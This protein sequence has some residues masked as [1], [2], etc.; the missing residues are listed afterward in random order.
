[1]R[2]GPQPLTIEEYRRRQGIT[3]RPEVNPEIPKVKPPKKRGGY[4]HRRK[5]ER[6][7]LIT[8]TQQE[9]PPSWDRATKIWTRISELEFLIDQYIRTKKKALK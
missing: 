4:V 5:K 6:V 3:T 2:T 8:E 9:N 1:M 7:L